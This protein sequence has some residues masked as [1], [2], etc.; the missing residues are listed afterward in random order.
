M[1]C[2]LAFGS[3]AAAQTVDKP[4]PITGGE[5][6]KWFAVA[7]VGPA[8]TLGGLWSSGYGVLTKEPEE[9]PSNTRG[10]GQRFGM[11]LT[12]VATGNAINAALGAAWGEDPRYARAASGGFGHRAKRVI[13]HTFVTKYKDGETRFAWARLAGNVSSNSLSNLWRV[14]S[15]VG[16]GPAASRIGFGFLGQMTSNAFAEF[17][18]DVWKKIRG[19]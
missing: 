8:S 13:G 12:G 4:A 17:M 6:A 18:P 2:V 11:R 10:F 3:G 19:K 7:T 9:Y 15:E 16:A 5:R 14:Q 1:A